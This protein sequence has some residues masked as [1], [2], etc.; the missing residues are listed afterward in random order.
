METD[1][2]VIYSTRSGPSH[3]DGGTKQ[4]FYCKGSIV[5]SFETPSKRQAEE[6]Q[7][8]YL[9]YINV[10]TLLHLL[11]LHQLTEKPTG[12]CSHSVIYRSQEYDGGVS[13]S[14]FL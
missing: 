8:V 12:D 6:N 10:L 5:K 13:M 9:I 3:C 11:C 1:I 2:G 4:I 7:G 14:Y